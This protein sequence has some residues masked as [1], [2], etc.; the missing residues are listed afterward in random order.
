MSPEFLS[1]LIAALVGGAVGSAITAWASVA[2]ARSQRREQAA[3]A[4]WAYHYALAG[5]AAKAGAELGP[6]EDVTLIRAELKDVLRAL[7]SA[8]PFAGYLSGKSRT[9]LFTG[10]WI[11]T[12]PYSDWPAQAQQDY[13]EFSRLAN[14]LEIELDW[15]FPRR[16]FDPIR[17]VAG[18]VSSWREAQRR[19]ALTRKKRQ[20]RTKS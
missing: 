15:A 18:R 19:K 9:S 7:K 20:E 1:A 4:L 5:F 6:S 16:F 3:A 12:D 10:A 17:S 2:I 11:T 14:L 13:Y 8:Y